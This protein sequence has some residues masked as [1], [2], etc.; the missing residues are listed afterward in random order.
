MLNK[1]LVLA[2]LIA[3]MIA[4]GSALAAG[5]ADAEAAIGAAKAAQKAAKSVGGEW[6]D[7]GKVIKKAEKAVAD[8]NYADAVKMAKKAESQ[9]HLGKEQAM[10]QK[11]VGNPKYLYN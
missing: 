2:A 1:K 7:T 3:G 4:T 8:G 9:G 10:S 6:R 5:K 11:G